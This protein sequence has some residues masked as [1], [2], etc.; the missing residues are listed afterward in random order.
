[1]NTIDLID[2]APRST[3]PLLLVHADADEHQCV[4]ISHGTWGF[5][6]LHGCDRMCAPCERGATRIEKKLHFGSIACQTVMQLPS[7][8]ALR[9]HNSQARE[10]NSFVCMCV[11]LL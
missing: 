6:L 9:L 11:S 5:P 3:A 1:M 2:W 7:G 4:Y 10:T 8:G